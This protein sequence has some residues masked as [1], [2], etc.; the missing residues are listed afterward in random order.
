M[1]LKTLRA[2][3]TPYFSLAVLRKT[4]K[5]VTLGPKKLIYEVLFRMDA[6]LIITQRISKF[7]GVSVPPTLLF[8]NKHL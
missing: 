1:K 4:K 6:D 2:N 5:P 7:L 8:H 3:K